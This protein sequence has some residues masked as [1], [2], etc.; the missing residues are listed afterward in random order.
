MAKYSLSKEIKSLGESSG[1]DAIGFA[2]ASEFSNYLLNEHQRRNPKLTLP[3]AK[4][5][6]VGGIY[7]GGVTM[8]EWDN[9]WYGRTS[10]LYLSEF[11]LDV[12][13]PL[14]PISDFLKTKGYQAIVCDGSIQGGSIIPLKLAAIRAGIGWQGKHSLLLSKKFGTF[15]ALGGIIT[16]ANL[17]HNAIEEPDR[18][19]NCDKCQ[20]A[21]PMAALDQPYVLNV[22]KCMSYQFQ[23]DGLSEEAQASMENRVGDCEICQDSCPWN[24]KHVNSPLI[25]KMTDHFQNKIEEWGDS[26]YLP[27]LSRLSENG[28]KDMFGYLNTGISYDL[29]HRNVLI[30]IEKAE[31]LTGKTNK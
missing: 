14:E 22:K 4:S 19:R 16:D 5:I 3:S 25:T 20:T 18:C 2:N 26:F 15:L 8:P 24:G 9:P 29:F 21:C 23:V 11:F 7:I 12:V 31:K 10:R 27:K 30:A 1:I 17:D 13:K 28:Y 6:I